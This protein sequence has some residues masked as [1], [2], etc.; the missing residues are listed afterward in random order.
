M[1]GEIKMVLTPMQAESHEIT[2]ALK[3]AANVHAGQTNI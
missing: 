2:K 1:D 3:I